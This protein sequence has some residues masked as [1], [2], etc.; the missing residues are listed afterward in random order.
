MFP[1][2][3]SSNITI[4][5]RDEYRYYTVIPVILSFDEYLKFPEKLSANN[6]IKF[7]N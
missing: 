2:K 1:D 3:V 6:N 4:K 7:K 5:L